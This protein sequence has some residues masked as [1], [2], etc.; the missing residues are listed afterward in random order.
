MGKFI[1]TLGRWIWGE[2]ETDD[3]SGF[4]AP[5]AA[6]TPDIHRTASS[7]VKPIRVYVSE[8]KRYEDVKDLANQLKN[9]KQVVINFENT[10]ADISRQIIDFLDGT[11]YALDGKSQEMGRNIFMFVPSHVEFNMDY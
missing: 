11:V 3:A 4:L 10:P 1:D 7:S 6:S 8:P 5:A 2:E 9:R